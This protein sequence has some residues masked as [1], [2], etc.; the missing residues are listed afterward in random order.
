MDT[1]DHTH[2]TLDSGSIAYIAGAQPAH[3]TVNYTS[4]ETVI[5]ELQPLHRIYT[6]NGAD[7]T[8]QLVDGPVASV[9]TTLPATSASTTFT[10]PTTD[11]VINGGVGADTFDIQ[12]S[13]FYPISVNG[14]AP[15]TFVGGDTFNLDAGSLGAAVI[16]L[17][18]ASDNAGTYSFTGGFMDLSYATMEIVG[19]RY[20]DPNALQGGTYKGDMFY[21]LHTETGI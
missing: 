16:T 2:A 17:N 1:I 15:T 18:E 10:N 7:N 6:F 13:K 11:L 19:M 4:V 3:Q 5:D 12:P 8:V 21:P 9:I 14:D 20:S